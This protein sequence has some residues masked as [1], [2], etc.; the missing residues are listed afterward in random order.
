MRQKFI[1]PRSRNNSNTIFYYEIE[2]NVEFFVRTTYQNIESH[3]F[4]DFRGK[5]GFNNKILIVLNFFVFL[6]SFHEF[7]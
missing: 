3:I 5:P 2:K 7:L 6:Y 1:K 4:I